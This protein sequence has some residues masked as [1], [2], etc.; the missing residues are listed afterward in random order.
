MDLNKFKN[1]NDVYG[2]MAGDELLRVVASRV[3]KIMQTELVFRIGGDEFAMIL[4]ENQDIQEIT[5]ALQQ[6]VS[7]PVDLNKDVTYYPSIS[8]GY[9]QYSEEVDG[10]EELIR[11]ADERMYHM[12]H[13]E[14]KG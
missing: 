14:R 5:Q 8:F 1:V 6:E 3:Q 4:E 13:N 2:H 11:I 9:A 12:K 7:K 10:I